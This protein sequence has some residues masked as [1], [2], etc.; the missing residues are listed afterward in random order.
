MKTE[1]QTTTPEN[2]FLAF[3]PFQMWAQS[4]QAFAKMMTDA[5]G[6]AQAFGDQYAAL[7]SQAVT[8]AQGAIATWA[9]LAQDALAYTTQLT[10]ESR[11]LALETVR[12]M[13]A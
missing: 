11:K 9:Q 13:A 1:N 6:R 3:D 2:P 8:R 7:E 4:Q 12:R 10:T 5:C